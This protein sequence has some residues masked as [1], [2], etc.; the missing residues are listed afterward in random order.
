MEYIAR[1]IFTNLLE[2]SKNR[3]ISILLGPRQTGKTTLLKEL[4]RVLSKKNRCLFLDLDVLSNFESVSSFENL[5]NTITLHGYDKNE[6]KLFYLFLDEFHKYADLTNIIKNVYDNIENVK[7][8]ASG[9]SSVEIK[10]QAGESLAGRKIINEIYPLDFE[11]FLLFKKENMAIEMLKNSKKLDGAGL[12]KSTKVLREFLEEF[13]I[14]GGYPEVAL[15]IKNDEKKEVLKS[16][17]D[18]YL[19]KDIRNYVSIEKVLKTKKLVEFLAINHGQKIKYETIG[20]SCSLNYFETKELLEL[21]FET[22]LVYELKPFYIN[23]NKELVKIPKIYFIDNG[24]RNYFVNNF[25][26]TF[27]R[28]DAGFLLEAFVLGELLK[29]N[30]CKIKFWQDKNGNEVDFILENE[31]QAIEIKFK[32]KLKSEDFHS[33]KIF[34]SVYASFTS[35]IINL[36][37]QKKREKI[38]PI[39]PYKLFEEVKL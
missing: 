31:K 36:G 33:L 5:K 32:T 27:I 19:K 28:S 37:I 35:Y 2:Q 21:L 13:I 3:K 26:K 25:N 16:I 18:L 17:F 9:S 6:K 8:F 7:I 39:L 29:N 20:T 11:E 15:K 10:K 23:K 4:C 24:V 34:L 22:Y 30:K 38:K 1:K 14:Y 12:E